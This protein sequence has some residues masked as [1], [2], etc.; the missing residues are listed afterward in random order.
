MLDIIIFISK[1]PDDIQSFSIDF[2][3]M[4]FIVNEYIRF[5]DLSEIQNYLF[6]INL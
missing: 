4:Y 6:V 1:K 2:I 3:L 5:V